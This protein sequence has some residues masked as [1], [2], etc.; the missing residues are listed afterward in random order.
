MLAHH[1]RP[2]VE[3]QMSVNTQLPPTDDGECFLWKFWNKKKKSVGV[4]GQS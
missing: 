4:E 2:E 3:N 1:Q